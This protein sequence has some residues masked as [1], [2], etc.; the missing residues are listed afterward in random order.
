MRNPESWNE[1]HVA[2]FSHHTLRTSVVRKLLPDYEPP[3]E[4]MREVVSTSLLP[5]FHIPASYS[6]QFSP[7]KSKKNSPLTSSSLYLFQSFLSM[8]LL[9]HLDIITVVYIVFCIAV[10]IHTSMVTAILISFIMEYCKEQGR[11]IKVLQGDLRIYQLLV[12]RQLYLRKDF[13][14]GIKHIRYSKGLSTIRRKDKRKGL[15]LLKR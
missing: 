6:Y 10:P 12:L 5:A 2:E 1:F 13:L 8:N 7:N 4:R 9:P 14:D 3:H 15:T 11:N